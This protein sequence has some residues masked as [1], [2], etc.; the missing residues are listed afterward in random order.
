[1]TNLRS[2]RRGT[3]ALIGAATLVVLASCVGGET[4]LHDGT[5][6]LS[7]GGPGAIPGTGG[8]AGGARR[9]AARAGNQRAADCRPLGASPAM[10]AGGAVGHWRDGDDR[11]RQREP[12]WDVRRHRRQ[13]DRRCPDLPPN[14]G[15]TCAHAV[16]YGWCSQDWLGTSCQ[17]SCGK[18]TGGGNTGG[19]GNRRTGGTG[20]TGSTG[21][22]GGSGGTG[23]T[24][25]TG[26][27]GGNVAPPPNIT[28]GSQAWASRYWDCCKP[29]CGWKANVRSRQPMPSPATSRTRASATYDAKNACENGGSAFMCWSGA[30]WSVSDHA[31]L[32]LRGGVGRQLR[33]RPLLPAP[34]QRHRPQRLQRR[35]PVVQRQDMIVQ[36]HQQ[37]RRRGRPVRP[38]DPGRRRRRAERL[39]EA[40]GHFAISAPSTA[41]SSPAATATRTACSKSADRVRGQARA[42]GRLRLVPRLVRRAPTT[43]TSSTSGSPARRRSRRVRA[44]PIRA[45]RSC[46]EWAATPTP[47]ACDSAG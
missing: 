1:M 41:A 13:R 26:G 45:E 16:E 14:N 4:D 38:S 17:R 23:G 10:R 25:G 2:L 20:G 46:R 9:R 36:V 43:R 39:L 28:G 24:R 8:T 31:V 47:M 37:R 40:V 21:G 42:A 44:S 19:S 6:G 30:P 32:R 33:L 29:A 35:R 22:N 15:D 5:T 7:G 34:V 12:G 18:C 11:Q 27:N 3:V